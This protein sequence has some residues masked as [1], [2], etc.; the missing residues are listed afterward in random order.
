MKIIIIILI[1]TLTVAPITTQ[2]A[3]PFD[4]FLNRMASQAGYDTTGT[5]E[6]TLATTLGLIVFTLLTFIGVIFTALILYGGLR[7][8]TARG[9]EEEVTQA[10]KIIR[11][12]I[13]GLIITVA[14]YSIWAVLARVL[15]AG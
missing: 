6:T 14:S 1:I 9:N 3:N 13:I 11:N 5:S 15:L 12:S 8:M 2:A 10:K 7:W 4:E